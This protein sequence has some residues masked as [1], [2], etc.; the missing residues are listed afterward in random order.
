M[1]KSGNKQHAAK[2]ESS[3]ADAKLATLQENVDK[4]FI[5]VQGI[6]EL[7]FAVLVGAMKRKKEGANPFGAP[8]V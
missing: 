5:S 6:E 2:V 1:A 8:R 7:M 3:S 4:K